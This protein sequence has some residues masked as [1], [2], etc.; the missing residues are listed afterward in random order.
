MKIDLFLDFNIPISFYIWEM[1][2]FLDLSSY[3][4]DKF[5]R[6]DLTYITF[7]FTITSISSFIRSLLALNVGMLT[8]YCP[9]GSFCLWAK[10]RR[11]YLFDTLRGKFNYWVHEHRTACTP[12]GFDRTYLLKGCLRGSF[13]MKIKYI[14]IELQI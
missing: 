7:W 13:Q 9:K 1:A 11:D 8:W 12:K 3:I 6:M 2:L 5:S 10:G 14:T 4:L